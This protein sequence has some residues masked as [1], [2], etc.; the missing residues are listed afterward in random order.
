MRH[1]LN[2]RVRIERRATEIGGGPFSDD[3][4]FSDGAAFGA[5]QINDGYGNTLGGWI[6]LGDFRATIR[7]VNGG[8]I[9]AA[10]K[11][12][13]RGAVEVFL[14]ASGVTRNLR[15]DDVIVERRTGARLNV[16]HVQEQGRNRDYVV[17]TCERGGADG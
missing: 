10:S 7:D 14:R 12:S 9:M 1:S 5:A 2:D 17:A 11:L 13:G 8:E 15:A 3:T 6:S 16:R 4:T